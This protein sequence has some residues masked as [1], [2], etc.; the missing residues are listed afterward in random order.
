MPLPNNIRFDLS[1][2]LIHFFRQ[3]DLDSD[4]SVVVPEIMGF[5]N[6]TEDLRWTAIFMLRC[7]IRHQRLWAT[8]SFR[9]GV[10]TIYGPSP[11]VCFTDMPVAAFL[12]AAQVREANGEAMSTYALVFPKASMFSVGAN[13]VIYGLDDRAVKPTTAGEVRSFSTDVLPLNEQYR[14]V[15]YNPLRTKPLDWTHER[16]WRWPFRDDM[17]EFEKELKEFATI[18]DPESMPGL[19][20]RRSELKGMGVIVK[21]DKEARWV[22]ADILALVDRGQISHNHYRFVIVGDDVTPSDLRDPGKIANAINAATIDLAPYFSV[23]QAA[24]ADLTRRFDH[25]VA[26][27]EATAPE[28]AARERGGAWLWLL[29]GSHPLTRVLLATGRVSVSKEGRYLVALPEFSRKLWLTQREEMTARLA[30]LVQAEFDLEADYFSVLNSWDY[31]EVPF[32]VGQDH[33]DNRTFFN[34]SWLEKQPKRKKKS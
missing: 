19:R 3:V 28:H 34:V 6:L 14:F 24:R 29:D 23:S 22:V 33:M 9:K 32:Y 21:T 11:A 2:Y 13:P 8:W 25:L 12:E 16:E 30:D 10:R 18:S 31:D 1:D 26:S 15:A 17:S 27:V 4:A 5:N 7:A 20:L